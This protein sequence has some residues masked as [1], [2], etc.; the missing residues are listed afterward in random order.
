MIVMFLA[1]GI[2][3]GVIGMIVAAGL[4]LGLGLI[5]AAYPVFGMLGV[6]LTATFTLARRDA[7][8]AESSLG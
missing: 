3:A 6:C 8:A 5:L 2:F 4:G 1:A 7:P